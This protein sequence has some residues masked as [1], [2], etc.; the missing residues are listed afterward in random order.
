[1]PYWWDLKYTK[2]IPFIGVLHSKGVWYLTASDGQTLVL[3]LLRVSTN[4]FIVITPRF[5]SDL[6]RLYLLGSIYDYIYLL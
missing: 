5:N 4:H 3:E 2:S 6:E 1:M